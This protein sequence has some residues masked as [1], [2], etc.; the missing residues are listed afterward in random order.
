[1]PDLLLWSNT[2][3]IV[4]LIQ[5]IIKHIQTNDCVCSYS[6][7]NQSG[8]SCFF[9]LQSKICFKGCVDSEDKILGIAVSFNKRYFEKSEE[10]TII[11][12]FR[13]V[14]KNKFNHAFV[15]LGSFWRC[16][17]C[18]STENSVWFWR[19]YST[20]LSNSRITLMIDEQMS[21]SEHTSINS[22]W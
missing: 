17:F 10:Q 22:R 21:C 14:I 7:M 19:S 9:G 20:S 1:M 2:T 5:Y 11:L 18:T 8:I 3:H 13:H 6:C 4:P 16:S 12:V 15:I